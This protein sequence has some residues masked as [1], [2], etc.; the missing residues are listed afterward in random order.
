MGFEPITSW[1][2]HHIF[3][4]F[5]LDIH[6]YDSLPNKGPSLQHSYQIR[7]CFWQTDRSRI[8]T[9]YFKLLI[10]S[11]N[12]HSYTQFPRNDTDIRSE[13][14]F[15]KQKRIRTSHLILL[16]FSTWVSTFIHKVAST[17]TVPLPRH[18]PKI[19]PCFWQPENNRVR[20]NHQ[21]LLSSCRNIHKAASTDTVP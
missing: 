8:Q 19:R 20:T 18:N 21:I 17:H 7:V 13:Y 11:L 10:S 2:H 6:S 12:I 9:H 5:D 15:D 4:C 16:T 1:A 3:L 14:V